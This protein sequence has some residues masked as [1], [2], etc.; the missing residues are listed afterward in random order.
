MEGLG[1]LATEMDKVDSGSVDEAE[2]VKA[3]LKKKLVTA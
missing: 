3:K 1:I 2:P